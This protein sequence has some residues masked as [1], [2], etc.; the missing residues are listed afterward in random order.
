MI[1]QQNPTLA[2]FIR[3]QDS[4]AVLNID[5]DEYKKFKQE[6]QRIFKMDDIANEV[7]TLQKD[8]SEIKT[9]LQQLVNG[10]PN[11]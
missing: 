9:L 6:R 7:Q 10:K 2:G 8:M 4:S 1:Q 5:S 3:S 11:G